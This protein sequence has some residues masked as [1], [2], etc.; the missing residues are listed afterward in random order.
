MREGWSRPTR[1]CSEAAE[2][3]LKSSV[4]V[5]EAKEAAGVRLSRV[6]SRTFRSHTVSAGPA[7]SCTRGCTRS[8]VD[9]PKPNTGTLRAAVVFSSW[10]PTEAIL[11]VAVPGPGESRPR[12][13]TCSG[14]WLGLGFG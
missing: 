10:P 3:D 8:L 7:V 9:L 13:S 14:L 11:A 4:S 5:G 12:S 2:L 1:P 6:N